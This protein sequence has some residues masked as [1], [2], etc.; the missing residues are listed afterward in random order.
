MK[1]EIGDFVT[2]DDP[3]FKDCALYVRDLSEE[4][5]MVFVEDED[6]GFGCWP[7]SRI[8]LFNLNWSDEQ[9]I[10]WHFTRY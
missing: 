3:K 5:E 4:Y 8:H 2:T 1:D 6:I 7:I 10:L 9:K